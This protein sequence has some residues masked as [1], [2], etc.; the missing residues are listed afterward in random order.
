MDE[1]VMSEKEI[2]E[3]CSKMG[4]E[5][6]I[7]LSNEEK[8]P[9]FICVMKGAMNFMVDLLKRVDLPLLEDYVQLQSYSGTH[10]TG[11]VTLVKDVSTN[12]DGRTVV[13]VED[14]VDTGL[15]MNF[16]LEHLQKSGH[17]KRI[18]VCALFDK[19]CARKVETQ[20]DFVGRTLTKN[21]FL[22]GYGLDYEGLR[23]NNPFVYVP[24][25]QEVEEM[26]EL[27]AKKN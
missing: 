19:K 17:A 4:Q 20:V 21:K 27:I 15:S 5:L 8:L 6:T 25:S 10:S 22:L 18:I 23:R 26:D 3:V 24:T 12:Y 16:L 2:N 14:I 1:M 9:L 13:V 11:T 7:L